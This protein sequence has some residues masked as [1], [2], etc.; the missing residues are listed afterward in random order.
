MENPD[1]VDSNDSLRPSLIILLL[2]VLID[3]MTVFIVD[4]VVVVDD[5]VDVIVDV[6]DDVVFDAELVE[7]RDKDFF[8]WSFCFL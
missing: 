7:V 8:S 5:V 4:D 6:I 3:G 2:V 1:E